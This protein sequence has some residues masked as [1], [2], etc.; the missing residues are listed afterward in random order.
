VDLTKG[1]GKKSLEKL[2]KAGTHATEEFS[3]FISLAKDL[4]VSDRTGFDYFLSAAEDA[5]SKDLKD[6]VTTANKL[7]L[8]QQAN[9][10]SGVDTRHAFL[11]VASD[12]GHNLS[13]VID[14]A[15]NLIDISPGDF[16]EIFDSAEAATSK[17]LGTFVKAYV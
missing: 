13:G 6:L 1:L 14:M 11:M 7:G 12:A 2:I 4:K 15:N 16:V 8:R 5:S 3:N 17:Y 10:R 9:N